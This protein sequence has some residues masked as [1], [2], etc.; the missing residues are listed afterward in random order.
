MWS[1]GQPVSPSVPLA[2][3]MSFSGTLLGQFLGMIITPMVA[4]TDL[5]IGTPLTS[6]PPHE[7]CCNTSDKACRHLA[8]YIPAGIMLA[9]FVCNIFFVLLDYRAAPILGTPEMRIVKAH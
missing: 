8:L 4:Q 1:D 2:Y 3:G 9:N 7:L 6:N 5:T